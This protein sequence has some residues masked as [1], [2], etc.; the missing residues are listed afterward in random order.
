MLRDKREFS[1]VPAMAREA[2]SVCATSPVRYGTESTCARVREAPGFAAVW[3]AFCLLR[4]LLHTSR[5]GFEAGG[6]SKAQMLV[7]GK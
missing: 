5:A 3:R 7:R 2:N 6:D 1:D 4:M